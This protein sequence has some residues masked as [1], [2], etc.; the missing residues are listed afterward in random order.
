MENSITARVAIGLIAAMGIME[1]VIKPLR[2]MDKA[3]KR[4]KAGRI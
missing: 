1:A 2:Q 4:N 3:N